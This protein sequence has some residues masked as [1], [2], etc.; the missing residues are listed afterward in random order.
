M[1]PDSLATKQWRARYPDRYAADLERS[2]Q[3]NATPEGAAANR[4]RVKAWREANPEKYRAQLDHLREMRAPHLADKAAAMR[5]HRADNPAH[6]WAGELRR[7]YGMAPED[8]ESMSA[9]QGGVCAICGRAESRVA[10]GRLLRLA[11]DHDHRTGRVRGLLC[12]ECNVGIGKL[13][14]SPDRLR[15]AAAYLERS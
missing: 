9:A 6:Y 8:Y 11:V 14:D 13:G 5:R 10:R 12:A 3:K 1:T 4:A 15:A 7:R 2:R